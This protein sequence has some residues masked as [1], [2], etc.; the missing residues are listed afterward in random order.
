VVNDPKGTGR[1]ARINGMQ[2][3]GK[4]G[5]AQV[6]ALPEDKET[7]DE[8]E[9]PYKFRDHSWFVAVAPA[10]NP[11]IAVSIIMEHSGM[12]GLKAAPIAKTIIEGYFKHRSG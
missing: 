4:T 2:V 12:E 9:I 5:T 8:K 3:A 1:E 6:I 7:I 11:E 10:E